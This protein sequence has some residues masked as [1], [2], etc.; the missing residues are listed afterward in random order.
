MK[1]KYNMENLIK[2]HAKI[3]ME[4]AIVEQ[5]RRCS[6]VELHPTLV[7]APLIY[8]A[9]G[10]ELLVGLYR[11]YLDIALEAGLPFFMCSPTWRA[12]VERVK[13]SDINTNINADAMQFMQEI[14]DRYPEDKAQIKI[15]GM[16]VCKGDC[17]KPE[18]ALS[19]SQA[20]DFHAWQINALA[21]A[22]ADFIIAE[23]L[24]SIEEA[25]FP[26]PP[27][28]H[29]LQNSGTTITYRHSYPGHFI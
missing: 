15:G 21:Q 16:I 11:S 8:D 25:L 22:G 9:R 12:N 18:E 6:D 24:P 19:C 23:T 10:R 26:N 14:R 4:G 20:Q 28:Y 1:M 2:S 7:N 5:L 27:T 3:L 13:N 17:Y 29:V